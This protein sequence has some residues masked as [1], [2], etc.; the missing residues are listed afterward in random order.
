M[1]TGPGSRIYPARP[2]AGVGAAVLMT[3]ADVEQFGG[4][5]R[6]SAGL[7]VVLVKRRFEPLAGEWSLPGGTLEVGETLRDGVVREIHEETGLR[8]DVGPVIEV[9]DRITR[10]PDARVRFHFVLIDYLCRPAGG[11]LAHASDVSEV[12]VADPQDLEPYGLT[13]ESRGVIRR[14][15]DMARTDPLFAS[16]RN[17]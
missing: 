13:A 12:V 1:T 10:D 6:I 7:A 2:I 4:G 9:M 8:V 11:R 15:A 3:A 5:M 17:G 14:A 16:R